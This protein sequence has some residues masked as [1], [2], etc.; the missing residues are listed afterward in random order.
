M[1]HV[2]ESSMNHSQNDALFDDIAREQAHFDQAPSA[3]F[4]AWKRGVELVG[5]HYFGD[6]T[7][8]GLQAAS[9]KW[10]LCPKI[11]LIRKAIGAM[12]SGEK[13]F[14]AA[15]VSF[16]NSKQGGALFKRVGIDGLADLGGLDSERRKVIAALML[17]YSGW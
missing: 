6:G 7:R 3:F 16:Y 4:E 10:D 11:A 2:V 12:S 15:M 17:Y 9:Q 1:S 8:Q 14:L 13:V 5:P